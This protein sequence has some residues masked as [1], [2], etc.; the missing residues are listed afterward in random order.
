MEQI[1]MM[2][3]DEPPEAPVCCSIFDTEWYTRRIFPMHGHDYYEMEFCIDG[4]INNIVNGS[5]RLMSRGT[6]I[7]VSPSD[8]HRLEIQEL[9]ARLLK[10]YFRAEA[11]SAEAVGLLEKEQLPLVRQLDADQTA[12]MIREFSVLQ[13]IWAVWDPANSWSTLRLRGAAELLLGRIMETETAIEHLPKSA[14][15][16][17]N[18]IAYIRRHLADPIRLK[19]IADSVWLSQGH[20]SHLFKKFTGMSVMEYIIENR[21]RMA[22]TLLTSSS[23][24]VN[25]IAEQVGYRSCS[26]FY[27]HFSEAFGA[28]PIAVRLSSE[29]E[30]SPRD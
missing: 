20:F 9:P 4:Q 16:I 25:K 18:A 5:A 8:L 14:E 30:E 7:F 26:L 6:L 19:D 24:P 17:M 27:R 10:L 29:R 13:E 12:V 28:S 22:R 2:K 15:P 23:L 21:M 3:W 1:Q 11:L